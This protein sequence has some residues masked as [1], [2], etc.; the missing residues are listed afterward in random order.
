MD[1]KMKSYFE[2]ILA[3]NETNEFGTDFASPDDRQSAMYTALAGEMQGMMPDSPQI[4]LDPQMENQ[5]V[6]REVNDIVEAENAPKESNI[7]DMVREYVK[8]KQQPQQLQD[9]GMV[10]GKEESLDD[11][12]LAQGQYED[13][14]EEKKRGSY[15][16]RRKKA[17]RQL[18][19]E[20]DK[21][22]EDT[23][24]DTALNWLTAIGAAATPLKRPTLPSTGKVNYWGSQRKK[25]FEE[26]K[27]NKIKQLTKLQNMYS[28]MK[29]EKTSDSDK[30]D[31]QIKQEKLKQ[32][33]NKPNI[34][35]NKTKTKLQ[36]E[37]EKNIAD[38][39][40]KLEVQKPEIEANVKI[41]RDLV[42]E[43]ENKQLSTGPFEETM[44]DIGSFFDTDE[45]SLKQKL[46]SLSTRAARAELKAMGEVRPT[47]ADVEGMKKALFNL[48]NTE[49]TNVD[50]LK[51]FIRKQEASLN[52]YN[53][54]KTKLKRGE[55]L[56]D[57]ILEPTLKEYQDKQKNSIIKKQYSP[58]RDKTK[59]TY[60]DGTEEVVDGRQ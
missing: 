43:I 27:A 12:R 28:S 51:D 59:I 15:E 40:S 48:G 38:R 50:K 57:F 31:L 29:K 56:E 5:M 1:D 23:G 30:L 37:M 44:G 25:Q 60:S 24:S 18:E 33:K 4:P 13:N 8:L 46:D 35:S 3:E 7:E 36:E 47:D 22:Y 32:L 20:I 11:L 39:Y 54:M 9:G 34:N 10:Q 41:A 55:G 53:Q 26:Q 6:Q 49:E 16:D 21:E 42:R 2:K 52:E 17:I 58:S 45:S 14:L 19:D